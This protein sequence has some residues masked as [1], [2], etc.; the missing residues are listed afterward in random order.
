MYRKI[1]L[2]WYK[3]TEYF[4]CCCLQLEV[5]C[6]QEIVRRTLKF[7]RQQGGGKKKKQ[8]DSGYG[9]NLVQSSP[10]FLWCLCW[11]F[12]PIT[13]LH[14]LSSV[15]WGTLWFLH[16]NN[17]LLVFNSWCFIGGF[18]SYLW[19]FYFILTQLPY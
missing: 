17:V 1:I 6:R 16:K 7:T 19:Y 9:S 10:L 13:W 14:I 3:L 4:F 18:M 15:L 12:G 11:S 8:T 5:D 2:F